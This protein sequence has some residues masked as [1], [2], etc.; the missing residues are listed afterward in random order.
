MNQTKKEKDLEMFINNSKKNILLKAGLNQCQ[1]TSRSRLQE[2]V[3]FK[4]APSPE[5]RAF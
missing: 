5:E 4:D 1:V 3:I 2:A